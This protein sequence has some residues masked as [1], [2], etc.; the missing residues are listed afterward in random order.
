MQFTQNVPFTNWTSVDFTYKF[1]NEDYTFIAG[2]TY[3]VPSDIAIHFAKH[4]AIREL[5][6]EGKDGLPEGEM[7]TYQAKCFPKGSP[8]STISKGFE[9]I[10]IQEEKTTEVKAP[11]ENK[12]IVEEQKESSDDDEADTSDEKNRAGVPKFKVNPKTAKDKAYSK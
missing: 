3:N 2:A 10:D 1:A 7:V 6:K 4:L 8:E 11:Q 12:T 5:H 9:R